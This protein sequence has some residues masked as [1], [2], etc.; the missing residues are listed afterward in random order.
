MGNQVPS[1][2][3][4]PKPRTLNPKPITLKQ[5]ST[6]APGSTMTSTGI[7]RRSS[8]TST[9][10]PRPDLLV[11]GGM[12]RRLEW[13]VGEILAGGCEADTRGLQSGRAEWKFSSSLPTV[14]LSGGVSSCQAKT[15]LKSTF[16]TNVV[17]SLQSRGS[18]LCGL[19]PPEKRRECRDGRGGCLAQIESG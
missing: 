17:P 13:C 8:S 16:S 3:P 10:L 11:E 18:S 2:L 9:A 12:R 15:S 5:G 19:E 6:R 14:D 4:N 1:T 7:S